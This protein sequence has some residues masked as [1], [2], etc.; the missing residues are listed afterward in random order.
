MMLEDEEIV[1]AM[2]GLL[3]AQTVGEKG[4]DLSGSMSNRIVRAVLLLSQSG[5]RQAKFQNM[6]RTLF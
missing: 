3:W 1:L 4:G 6:L 5:S 2:E